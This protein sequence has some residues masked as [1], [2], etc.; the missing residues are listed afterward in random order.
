MIDSPTLVA[1]A[2]TFAGIWAT[3]F[4]IGVSAAWVAK[5]KDVA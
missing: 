2:S 4:A 1:I 3:G 5:I